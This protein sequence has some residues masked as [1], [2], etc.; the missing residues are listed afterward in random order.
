MLPI[1]H[2][3]LESSTHAIVDKSLGCLP[4]ILAVLDFSTIKNELFPI[5]ATVFSKTSSLGIKVRGLEAF[6][7]LCGGSSDSE[8]DENDDFSGIS[9]APKPIRNSSAVL[10][11]YTVQEKIVPLL[12]AMKTKEPAVMM[13]ALAVF[14]QVGKIA[15]TE[16]LAMETL[17]ILWSFSLGPL[18]NLQQFQQFMDL[19][20]K[21][22]ARIESEQI[23]KLRDFSANATNSVEAS[24]SNDLMN[25][26]PPNISATA[27][28]DDV[29]DDDFQ[30]LVLGSKSAN[31]T[32]M[33]G[34]APA[35]AQP[36]APVSSTPSMFEWSSPRPSMNMAGMHQPSRTITP[37]HSM[38]SMGAF[39]TLSPTPS[40][41]AQG[42]MQRTMADGLNSF[43]PM[44]PAKS[45]GWPTMAPQQPVQ[46]VPSTFSLSPPPQNP[47]SNTSLNFSI[48]P[49]PMSNVQRPSI[50]QASGGRSMNS[51]H[52]TRQSNSM[53]NAPQPKK[54][55]LDAY[56]SLI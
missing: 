19:I 6:V 13:A 28:T 44:Q 20:K 55:G 49:P 8:P 5:V 12:K 10:D 53:T 38:N 40:T 56:E 11:K 36:N 15:D 32:D 52:E 47:S 51:I 48:A 42:G 54:T 35:S 34:D 21:L 22:S 7:T 50:Q 25:M 39:A 45:T 37:D 14:K 23:K 30:R 26:G 27:R 18:L 41:G 4:T 1:L 17:P 31:G 9:I 46:H 29:G 24:R 3:G 43:A 33:L 2:L 16:F